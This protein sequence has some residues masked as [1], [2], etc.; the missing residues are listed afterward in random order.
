ML[1]EEYKSNKSTIEVHIA[2]IEKLFDK[3]KDAYIEAFKLNHGEFLAMRNLKLSRGGCLVVIK[4]NLVACGFFSLSKQNDTV[5]EFGDLFKTSSL[6]SRHDFAKAMKIGLESA[7]GEMSL[8]GFYSYQNARALKLVNMAG[9]IRK[10][11]YERHISLVL[12][13]FIIKLPVKIIDR[14]TYMALDSITD[15][16]PFRFS[17]GLAKTRLSKF[18]IPYL[19]HKIDIELESKSFIAI[20]FLNEFY[21]VSHPAD[22]LMFF[23]DIKSYNLETGFEYSDNSA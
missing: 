1:V 15:H 2:P 11:Y 8:K 18:Y 22:S 20:G 6:L 13:N 5:G 4:I 10:T 17:F 12:L 19:R 14:K 9:F 21:D 16:P 3:Y 7:L 23:G